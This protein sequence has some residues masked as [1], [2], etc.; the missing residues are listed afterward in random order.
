MPKQSIIIAQPTT[1]SS[2]RLDTSSTEKDTEKETIMRAVAGLQCQWQQLQQSQDQTLS[3][4]RIPS[5]SPQQSCN[6]Q[7]KNYSLVLSCS[8]VCLNSYINPCRAGVSL[9]SNV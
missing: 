8:P 6:C 5:S 9:Q 2:S 7:M 3:L 1:K 4:A